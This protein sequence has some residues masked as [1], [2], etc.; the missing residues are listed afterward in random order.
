MVWLLGTLTIRSL[1]GGGYLVSRDFS[2]VETFTAVAVE[3][4]GCVAEDIADEIVHC[5]FFE[6]ASVL[7]AIA[8]ETCR[9]FDLMFQK[10]TDICSST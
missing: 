1:E 10:L 2:V 4:D 6:F 8:F 5:W 7:L 3:E 9:S